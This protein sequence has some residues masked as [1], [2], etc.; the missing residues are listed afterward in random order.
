MR[1]PEPA[2]S[3][4]AAESAVDLPPWRVRKT[5]PPVLPPGVL[6]RDRLAARLTTGATHPVT[7]VS[8]GP[9]WGKTMAAASWAASWSARE[10]VAWLSLDDSDNNPESFW[11]NLVSAVIGSGGLRDRTP[12]RGQDSPGRFQ[13]ADTEEP[14]TRLADLPGPVVLIIDDFQVIT[15]GDVL[16]RFGD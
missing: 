15:D 6:V 5:R 13:V 8:A 10:P 11:S 14:W 16:D 1:G 3:T 4:G 7:L 2:R 9:G 12:L